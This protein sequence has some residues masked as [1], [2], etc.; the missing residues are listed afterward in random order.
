MSILRSDYAP[1][2]LRRCERVAVTLVVG[3]AL[4]CFGVMAWAQECTPVG[5]VT[6]LTPPS[7]YVGTVYTFDSWD[8]AGADGYAAVNG[9]G[10]VV[11][12][13][14]V[15]STELRFTAALAAGTWSYV[16]TRACAAEP[17]AS[18]ASGAAAGGVATADALAALMAG[19]LV[20]LAGVGYQNGRTR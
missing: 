13:C 11:T 16:W 12:A 14:S 6:E 17:P 4:L 9:G 18:G 7:G 2:V 3:L 8:C 15:T 20:L 19:F 10:G 5:T 1:Q